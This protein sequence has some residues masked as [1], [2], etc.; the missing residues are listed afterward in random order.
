MIL[1]KISWLDLYITRS[2]EI[3]HYKMQSRIIQQQDHSF[4]KQMLLYAF[5]YKSIITQSMNFDKVSYIVWT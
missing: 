2:L 4:S 3:V 5:Q 1:L